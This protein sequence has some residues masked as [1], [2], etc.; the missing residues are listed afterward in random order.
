VS[1]T[2]NP[3]D[4]AGRAKVPLHLWPAT[5]TAFG[6]MGFQEGML[7]YGRNNWRATPVSAAVYA[8][9]AKR[10]IDAWME[11]Q[12]NAPDTGNPH[13]GNALACLAILVDAQVN[14]T[15]IDDRNYTPDE[16][17]YERMMQTLTQ[18]VAA[19]QKR[20]ADK[21]PKH[22]DRRDN[23]T[24]PVTGDRHESAT[25]GPLGTESMEAGR[26]AG[27]MAGLQL[28]AAARAAAAPVRGGCDCEA[29]QL[30]RALEAAGHVVIR[31]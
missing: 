25:F 18:Q 6:A 14:G 20:F 13:L 15:L 1:D 30:I 28:N 5:A 7:K 10:H 16:Q 21:T 17:A 24:Q 8:A 26:A 23:H 29:C 3:K 12:D 31:V 9:A 27:R 11:G 22:W 4:A 19:L 2:A